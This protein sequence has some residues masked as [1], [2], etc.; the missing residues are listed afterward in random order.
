[1]MNDYRFC[2]VCNKFCQHETVMSGSV[3]WVHC[4]EC[5]IH[6][7]AIDKPVNS[8]D[9]FTVGEKTLSMQDVLNVY[10]KIIEHKISKINPQV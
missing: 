10:H 6:D 8:M 4:V 5:G 1:M 3:R 2:G 9:G 7:E